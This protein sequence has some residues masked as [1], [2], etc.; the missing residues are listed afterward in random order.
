MTDFFY[1]KKYLHEHKYYQF[2]EKI[3]PE[4]ESH[5]DYPSLVAIVDVLNYYDIE[6]IAARID[7]SELI[8]LPKTFLSVFC[9]HTGNEIVYTKKNGQNFEIQFA[10][11]FIQKL[12]RAEYLDGWNGM[13]VA[14]EENENNKAAES[15]IVSKNIRLFLFGICIVAL[16]RVYI[17]NLPN[18]TLPISHAI[19]SFLGLLISVFL[20]R[21]DLGFNDTSISKICQASKKTSCKDVLFSNRAKILGNLKLSDAS[22][23]YFFV[24]TLFSV[25]LVFKDSFVVYSCLAL[26]SVPVVIYS[27]FTQYFIVKKWCVLCLGIVLI[28]VLHILLISIYYFKTTILNV[29]D[30]EKLVSFLFVFVLTTFIFL[31]IKKL[32]KKDLVNKNIEVK[33]NQLKRKYPV[34]K[35]LLNSDK[36]IDQDTLEEMEA[37]VIGE[38][39]APIVLNAVLSASC[40][41]CHKVY[42]NLIKLWTKNPGQLKIRLVFNVNAENLNNPYNVIYK[43][44]VSYY[45]KG[46]Q[47][48][49]MAVLNDW[50]I[51][52]ISFEEWK[53]RWADEQAEIGTEIIQRQYHWCLEN[54]IFHTPAIILNGQLLPKEYDVHE[55]N[56][57]I[58]NLIEEKILVF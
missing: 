41:H 15:D 38:D 30:I 19:A 33:Y 22:L 3:V 54:K 11:G 50:H 12:S 52:R 44:A 57:F 34:F 49:V 42:Q 27:I 14:I 26:L 31:E 51:E 17:T 58:N 35:A 7:Q 46:D 13:I 55:L 1:L 28:L 4:L 37:V 45:L 40:I 20:V 24:L 25:F 53:L 48:K 8:N 29:T 10:N 5:P 23:I 16:F 6:N 2:E 43:Q 36:N 47:E 32:I 18:P 9:T 21:E 56:F 39:K